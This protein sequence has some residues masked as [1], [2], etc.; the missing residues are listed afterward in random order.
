MS[1][2]K[3]KRIHKLLEEIL[4]HMEELKEHQSSFMFISGEGAFSMAGKPHDVLSELLV[5]MVMHPIVRRMVIEAVSQYSDV[6]R[7]FGDRIRNIRMSRQKEE[8][9]VFKERCEGN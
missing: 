7:E 4:D 9:I 6:E 1:E 5:A 3:E 8:V 2:D